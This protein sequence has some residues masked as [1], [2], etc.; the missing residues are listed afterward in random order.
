M[1]V[2]YQGQVIDGKL[3]LQEEA[4]LPEN[5]KVVVTLL[6]NPLAEDVSIPAKPHIDG[7]TQRA[8]FEKFFAAMKE[9]DDEPITDEMI[10][11]LLHNRVN[12]R[13]ALDL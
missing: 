12:I 1:M 4:R 7:E 11:E 2:S 9:I 10:E 6:D 3:V 8:A 5:A 13:R